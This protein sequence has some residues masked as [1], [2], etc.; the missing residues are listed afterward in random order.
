MRGR[1]ISMIPG[2]VLAALTWALL[3]TLLVIE[4]E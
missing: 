1:L 2:A 3:W 4:A